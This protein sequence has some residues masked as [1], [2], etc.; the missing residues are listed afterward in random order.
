MNAS[1]S[2]GGHNQ[3]RLGEFDYMANTVAVAPYH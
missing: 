2:K 1:S 3:E